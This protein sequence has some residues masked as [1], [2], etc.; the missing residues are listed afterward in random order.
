MKTKLKSIVIAAIMLITILIV[1]Q[2]LLE[3]TIIIG[4]SMEPTYHSYQLVF[5]NKIS[6]SYER[7]SVVIARANNKL[8][9]KRIIGLPGETIQ[10][11]NGDVYINGEILTDI[12]CE[13]IDFAGT[14]FYPLTLGDSEYFVLGDNRNNST[15][16]R[17]YEIG[18]IT[19]NNL[20][21]EVIVK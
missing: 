2:Y 14:A 8:I 13:Y 15:D 11:K 3:A 19:K 5:I 6:P 7:F 12:P 21:G 16:S 9:I 20:R 10:I 18:P 1:K 4:D 17:Y